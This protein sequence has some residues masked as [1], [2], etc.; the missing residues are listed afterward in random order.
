MPRHEDIVGAEVAFI[1][2]DG[3][4]YMSHPTD[5]D[6]SL[7]K[8]VR[9]IGNLGHLDNP[10]VESIQA[11]LRGTEQ[12][13]NGLELVGRYNMSNGRIAPYGPVN[14]AENQQTVRDAISQAAYD[15]PVS[16]PDQ[17]SGLQTTNPTTDIQ[18]LA[19]WRTARQFMP[20]VDKVTKDDCPFCK[21]KR[22]LYVMK[23][24]YQAQAMGVHG[25][26]LCRDCLTTRMDQHEQS[27]G[28]TIAH[29]VSH[30][31]FVRTS[32]DIHELA[33][34]QLQRLYVEQNIRDPYVSPDPNWSEYQKL[35]AKEFVDLMD[36]LLK[37]AP[38]TYKLWPFLFRSYKKDLVP[39]AGED[40]SRILYPNKAHIKDILQQATAHLERMKDDPRPEVRVP[41]F[42]QEFKPGVPGTVDQY[43]TDI[44]TPYSWDKLQD[45]VYKQNE[46]NAEDEPE[47]ET[48]VFEWPDGWTIKELGADALG[49]EGQLMGH[50]VGGYCSDVRTH[51]SH[52]YSLRD[53]KN[54]P[55]VTF[56]I[57][58]QPMYERLHSDRTPEEENTRLNWANTMTY[59]GDPAIYQPAFGQH[60]Y[61]KTFRPAL[62]NP[63]YPPTGSWGTG[64]YLQHPEEEGQSEFD[65]HGRPRVP[66]EQWPSWKV[67]QIQGKQ[68]EEP[69]P[70]YRQRIKEYMTY[71]REKEGVG[72]EWHPTEAIRPGGEEDHVGDLDGVLNYYRDYQ[73]GNTNSHDYPST[74]LGKTDPYDDYGLPHNN[75]FEGEGGLYTGKDNI[76]DMI[77]EAIGEFTEG[78]DSR[79]RR[80]YDYAGVEDPDETARAI[81]FLIE[82][83]KIR[84]QL[85]KK[86]NP[87]S[88]LKSKMYDWDQILNAAIEAGWAKIDKE[89]D[90]MRDNNWEFEHGNLQHTHEQ[91]WEE[92]NR[93]HGFEE[94]D[95]GYVDPE[96][97]EFDYDHPDMEQTQ[98]Y[99]DEELYSPWNKA[100][101]FLQDLQSGTAIQQHPDN[102][103]LPGEPGAVPHDVQQQMDADPDISLKTPGALSRWNVITQT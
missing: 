20:L 65:M 85:W 69:I 51:S 64:V 27:T 47:D 2:Y 57:E 44:D 97:K 42:M 59:A 34:K 36:Y 26:P 14:N 16:S 32:A 81:L 79:R 93:E 4:V 94:G 71:L 56:E 67:I 101:E 62:S 40:K 78:D 82:Q 86:N 73:A 6:V 45:W 28:Q 76:E 39:S 83:L 1:L 52:I 25:Y 37:E 54:G 29:K 18:P 19:N 92:Y 21:Q 77:I 100:A 5:N 95:E 33:T 7:T 49:K 10:L 31:G 17:S 75:N 99:I 98:N 96:D 84:N 24:G 66:E 38:E 11:F 74:Q 58:G 35:H 80:Y 53:P 3:Q 89:R 8:L 61:H 43:G 91:I 48:T 103:K 60:E 30:K 13:P 72:V 50:C 90:S 70:E 55:H 15:A 46:Q 12:A 102:I 87:D 41:N 23:D 22:S 88:P 68:D 9:Q 63:P